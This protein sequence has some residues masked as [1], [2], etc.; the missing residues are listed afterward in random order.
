[1]DDDVGGQPEL[2]ILST[3]AKSVG[4]NI[5]SDGTNSP[6]AVLVE[7]VFAHFLSET[8]E[9]IVLQDVTGNPSARAP[10]AGAHEQ[11]QFAV[12]DRPHQSFDQGGAKEPGRTGYRNSFSRK[13]FAYHR[14]LFYQDNDAL[15]QLVESKDLFVQ[16]RS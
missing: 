1:M 5:S 9:R 8:I 15:Y 10:P 6:F 3:Q 7:R 16:C 14:N 4:P 2:K 11:D 13:T 12:G